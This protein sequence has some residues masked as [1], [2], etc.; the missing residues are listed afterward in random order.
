[1][2]VSPHAQ[3]HTFSHIHLYAH[4]A[5]AKLQGDRDHDLTTDFTLSPNATLPPLFRLS[6]RLTVAMLESLQLKPDT[7]Y[8]FCTEARIFSARTASAEQPRMSV[9]MPAPALAPSKTN[10]ACARMCV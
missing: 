3:S 5:Q 6:D 4:A 7:S 9:I 2:Y 1:V 8:I 10:G